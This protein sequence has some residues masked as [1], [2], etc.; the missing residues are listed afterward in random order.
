VVIN[1]VQGQSYPYFY[2]VLVAR[3]D[4]GLHQAFREFKPGGNIT[5]EFKPQREVEVLIIRQHTTE[6]SGYHT[7]GDT[8]KSILLWGLRVAERVAGGVAQNG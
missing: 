1:E 7:D 3:R 6:E 5:K 4:F 8:A 2:V